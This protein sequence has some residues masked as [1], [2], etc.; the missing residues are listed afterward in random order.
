M[1]GQRLTEVVEPGKPVK[2]DRCCVSGNIPENPASAEQLTT[3]T[4][5]ELARPAGPKI[6]TL[7]LI[8]RRHHVNPFYT[9]THT[10]HGFTKESYAREL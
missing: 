10:S 4:L 1:V 5:K 8:V 7:S 6:T 2:P 9:H 3:K